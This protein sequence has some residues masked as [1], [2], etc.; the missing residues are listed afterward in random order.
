MAEARYTAAAFDTRFA[1]RP[2]FR[3][4][5]MAPGE[6]LRP[7]F[8]VEKPFALPDLAFLPDFAIFRGGG[9]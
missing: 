1:K 7:A 5:P 8:F 9:G 6:N 4:P 3:L 2:R